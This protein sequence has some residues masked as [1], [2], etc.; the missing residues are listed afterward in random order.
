MNRSMNCARQGIGRGFFLPEIAPG[1]R[2]E[3]F[4][5]KAGGSRRA[6]PSEGETMGR[7][8][9]RQCQRQRS[10][11]NYGAAKQ[12]TE[13]PLV[14]QEFGNKRPKGT[15]VNRAHVAQVRFV[16]LRPF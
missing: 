1:S 8:D 10:Q 7:R 5:K 15:A 11:S 16:D 6:A 13:S 4:S 14:Y 2:R 12:A 9:R 3:K